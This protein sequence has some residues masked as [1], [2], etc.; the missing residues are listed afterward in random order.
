MSSAE[1]WA[2]AL[3]GERARFTLNF[4]RMG[5][6][7]E[8]RALSA[9]EVEECR[10]MGGER[11]MRYAL[12]LACGAVREAGEQLR[13]QGRAATPFDATEGLP[14]ADV[15]AAGRAIL[16]QSGAEKARLRLETGEGEGLPVTEAPFSWT[17]ETAAEKDEIF[18][19]TEE[20]GWESAPEWG[21]AAAFSPKS[22]RRTENGEE[23]VRALAEIFADRLERARGNR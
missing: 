4:E 16:R 19:E 23:S 12:Y 1:D 8:C 10:R 15:L 11:G 13:A 20:N 7:A 21:K 9:A 3:G 22:A 17:E 6:A 5:V 2:R 14:Y 18:P